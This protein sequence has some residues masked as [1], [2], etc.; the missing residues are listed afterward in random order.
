M[1]AD[2]LLDD[3]AERS[4]R[5]MADGDYIAAR[6]ACRAALMTQFLWASQQAIEK[7]LKCILLL[8]RIPAKAVRHNLGEAMRKIDDSDKISLDLTRGTE[9]FISM[10]DRFGPHR[11]LEVSNI[12]FG[13]DL[14]TLDRSRAFSKPSPI[15]MTA[16][17]N[18]C[19]VNWSGRVK[20][21]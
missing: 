4:F 5:D 3:F 16:I 7:Y 19:C 1:T 10:L 15:C 9:E 20:R 18:L 17:G 21:P 8:N 13:A 2:A 6:M 11:Y 12:G 14:V